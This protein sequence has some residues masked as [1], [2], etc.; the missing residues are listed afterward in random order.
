MLPLAWQSGA[1][2]ARTCD[3]ASIGA[4]TIGA[5]AMERMV[6][7][8]RGKFDHPLNVRPAERSIQ[9][10]LYGRRSRVVDLHRVLAAAEDHLAVPRSAKYLAAEAT[11]GEGP[12][13]SEDGLCVRDRRQKHAEPDDQERHSSGQL[14]DHRGFC[15]PA[16][17]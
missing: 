5:G 3:D 6:T 8:E 11:P 13:R 7:L 17:R 16:L 15:S 4:P 14:L 9:R 1:H 2:R 10:P 12:E